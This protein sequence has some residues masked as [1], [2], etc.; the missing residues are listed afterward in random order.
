MFREFVH[1]HLMKC[2]KMCRLCRKMVGVWPIT[3]HGVTLNM[4]AVYSSEISKQAKHSVQCKNA[5]D[6]HRFHKICRIAGKD[7][8]MVLNCRQHSGSIVELSAVT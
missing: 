5:E 7:F 3:E 4:E 1:S 6:D 2:K 8:M